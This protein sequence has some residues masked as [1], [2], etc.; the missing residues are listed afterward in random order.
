MKLRTRFGI[1]ILLLTLLLAGGVY[2][3]LEVYKNNI[4]DDAQQDVNETAEMSVTQLETTIENQKDFVG[5]VASRPEAGE[6]NQSRRFL[7]QFV[8]NSRF[9][10]AQIITSNGTILDFYGDITQEVQQESIGMDVTDRAYYSE[11]AEGEIYISDIEYTNTTD[12]YFVI[13]SAPIFEDRQIKGVLS[14][15]IYINRQTFFSMVTPL[16][17]SDQRVKID[18]GN[19]TLYE[20]GGTFERSMSFT[21]QVEGTDWTITVS[22]N[23][24]PLDKRLNALAIGQGTGLLIVLFFVVG[25]ATWQYRTTLTETNKLLQGFSAL[26]EGEFDHRIELHSAD[27]WREIG[28]GFN[29]LAEELSNWEKALEQ[30]KQRLEVLNRVLRHNVRN[31]ATVISG[32]ATRIQEGTEDSNTSHAANRIRESIGEL[33]VLT[34]KLREFQRVTKED[35]DTHGAQDLST[36]IQ[37]VFAE[38]REEYPDISFSES[39]PSSMMVKGHPAIELAIRNLCENACEYNDAE[40]PWVRCKGEVDDQFARIRIE[41]NGPGIPEAEYEAIYRGEESALEHASGVGLW[42]V[43]WVIDDLDGNLRFENQDK[44]TAAIIEIETH[45]VENGDQS[46]N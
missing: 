32:F 8:D 37:E 22:R 26:E 41:D 29:Q 13:I 30:R 24:A 31:E 4:V 15:S 28:E 25:F 12:E 43:Q 46:K 5:F 9:F 20:G 21:E 35:D 44:G 2:G 1:S 42:I 17:T 14:A 11:A 19:T 10:A 23:R 45:P 33:E 7:Q 39:I 38:F 6:F 18:S 3:G 36:I 40:D 27:E 34:E 16:E